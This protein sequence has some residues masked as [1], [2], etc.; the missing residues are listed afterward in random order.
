MKKT[1]ALIIAT[2]MLAASFAACNSK[3]DV[4]STP[5]TNESSKPA[6]TESKPV[7][8][9]SSEEPSKPEEK[10]DMDLSAIIEKLYEQ[11]K[12]NEMYMM[13][14]TSPLT[15]DGF[16]TVEEY[17]NTVEML[18][19]TPDIKFA[20]CVYNMPMVG[21]QPYQLVLLR[22]EE[23]ADVEALKA[24]IKEKAN[25]RRWVCVCADTVKVESVGNTI[26]FIM[27]R[28]DV[29]EGIAEAFLNLNN[30]NF[31]PTVSINT[32]PTPEE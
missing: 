18:F 8:E 13:M 9:P 4:S 11:T 26:M 28:T 5:P 17:N 30:E 31:V 32:N 12:V 23:G 24:T 25:P 1:I 21:S 16:A 3:E 15:A 27:S 14:M 2:L 19:G 6:D 22:A 29:A 20:E 7:D 10:L